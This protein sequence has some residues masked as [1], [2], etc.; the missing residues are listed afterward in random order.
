MFF[1][2]KTQNK[3]PFSNICLFFLTNYLLILGDKRKKMKKFLSEEIDCNNDN[4]NAYTKEGDKIQVD[5]QN[6]DAH[7]FLW[8]D[9]IN[10]CPMFFD[11]GESQTEH[12][13]I[14]GKYIMDNY[15]NPYLREISEDEFSKLEEIKDGIEDTI[16]DIDVEDREYA[17]WEHE[18]SYYLNELSYTRLLVLNAIEYYCTNQEDEI[19]FPTYDGVANAV[20]ESFGF[21]YD[22]WKERFT[23]SY[24]S[25][26]NESIKD[27][28]LNYGID[29]F[30]LYDNAIAY[31]RIWTIDKCI[32]LVNPITNDDLSTLVN[33]LSNSLEISVDELMDYHIGWEELPY[34]ITIRDFLNDDIYEDEDE[35]D[36][37][38]DDEEEEELNNA[39]KRRMPVIH[40]MDAKAKRETD[41][42][43][44]YLDTKNKKYADIEARM[45][46]MGKP[47]AMAYYNSLKT[48]ESKERPRKTLI[49]TESQMRK[50]LTLIS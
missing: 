50:L 1:C 40:N 28:M 34:L 2:P 12:K 20:A 31:G 19:D 8:V 24:C 13:W 15:V 37:V 22:R 41:Q 44:N 16:N 18:L 3:C 5:W 48:Q 11:V 6:S 23:T 38:F 25:I 29:N 9:A 36:S 26:D 10:N 4:I 14:E 33:L 21:E 42:I 43:K 32:G 47:D 49:I 17:D 39:Q 35:D 45:R 30:I 7:P 46:K 27:F